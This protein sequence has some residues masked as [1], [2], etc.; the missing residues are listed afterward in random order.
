MEKSVTLTAQ[1]LGL[2]QV[3]K[4]YHNLNYDELFDAESAKK[5]G[6]VSANGTMMVDTGKFTGRS[7]KDKYFVHQRP[8]RNNFV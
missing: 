2:K 7:P 3:G 4:I 6:R 1:E 8:S 5:E